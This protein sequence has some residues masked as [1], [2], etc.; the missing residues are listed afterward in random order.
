MRAI[1]KLGLILSL[2][3]FAFSTQTLAKKNK[4]RLSVD[5]VNIVGSE[6]YLDINGKFKGDDGYEPTVMLAVNVYRQI[7]EDSLVILGEVTT[8]LEG[9]AKFPLTGIVTNGDSIMQ[10]IFVV[11]IENNPK[12]M[13]AK[14][15]VKFYNSTIKAI[16]LEDSIAVVQAFFLD[17]LGDPINKKKLDVKVKRLFAPLTIGESP[18]KTNGKGEVVVSMADSLPSIDGVLTIEVS[19]SS[20]KYGLVKYIF[21]APIGKVAINESTYEDRTMWSPPGKTPWVLIIF[22]ALL[23][24][25]VWGVIILLLSNLLKIYKS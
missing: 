9:N 24:F 15:A 22:P 23:I 12:F 20:K 13:D 18:Y 6:V 1:I 5:Y 16:I 8:N 17:E 2:C 21:D 14:K 3:I 11:K 4:A 7:T 25:S 19:H 10:H